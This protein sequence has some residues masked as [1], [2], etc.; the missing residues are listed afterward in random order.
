MRYNMSVGDLPAAAMVLNQ[1]ERL[2]SDISHISVIIKVSKLIQRDISQVR[3][4]ELRMSSG[5][6][7][8]IFDVGA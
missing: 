6:L 5:I 1:K 8:H 7:I 4:F 3:T 2:K